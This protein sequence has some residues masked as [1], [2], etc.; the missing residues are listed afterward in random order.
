MASPKDLGRG[1]RGNSP[2]Y[3]ILI[4]APA[5]ISPLM[6][7]F[8]IPIAK[9]MLQRAGSCWRRFEL[10]AGSGGDSDRGDR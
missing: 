9:A 5:M 8:F 3:Q 2:P 6:G 4:S 7:F 1:T 10:T